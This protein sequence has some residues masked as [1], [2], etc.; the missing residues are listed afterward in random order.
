M[1]Q[2]LGKCIVKALVTAS[3]HSVHQCYPLNYQVIS[4]TPL[5]DATSMSWKDWENVGHVLAIARHSHDP[6]HKKI[7]LP[8][9]SRNLASYVRVSLNLDTVYETKY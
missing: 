9:N 7:D 8:R 3:P 6:R 2:R 4:E 5:D 1:R